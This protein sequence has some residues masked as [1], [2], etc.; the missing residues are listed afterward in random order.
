VDNFSLILGAD[1][2]NLI[3]QNAKVRVSQGLSGHAVELY[4]E[5]YEERILYVVERRRLRER[6]ERGGLSSL[7]RG[8]HNRPLDL[9]CNSGGCGFRPDL[10]ADF[11][12]A[13]ETA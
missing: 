2:N 10:V 9:G 5:H 12:F 7:V 1:S 8:P 13:E 3:G 11:F 4:R 6:I